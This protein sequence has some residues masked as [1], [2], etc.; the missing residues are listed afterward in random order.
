MA[1]VPT[2]YAAWRFWFDVGQYVVTLAVAIFVWIL[3]RTN[4][5]SA[6]VGQLR[7][8]MTTMERR[9]TRLE[10]GADHA[11]THEDLGAVYERINDVGEQVAEVS[12]SVKGMKGTLDMIQEHLLNGGK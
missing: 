11:L 6:E 1:D 5:K 2:D 8:S 12:G 9:V 4:A 7:D 10:T 3:N